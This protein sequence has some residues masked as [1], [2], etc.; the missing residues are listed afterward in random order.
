MKRIRSSGNLNDDVSGFSTGR[1]PAGAKLV[2]NS[3]ANATESMHQNLDSENT[4]QAPQ[5]SEMGH[6]GESLKKLAAQG[7]HH[8]FESQQLYISAT[9]NNKFDEVNNARTATLT[10]AI[11]A[12]TESEMAKP[13]IAPE[14]RVCLCSKPKP[15]TENRKPKTENRKPNGG[16]HHN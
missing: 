3:N 7:S 2:L 14:P 10:S 9:D 15:K 8:S 12:G 5:N 13:F 6:G 1:L 16:S 4:H 11:D